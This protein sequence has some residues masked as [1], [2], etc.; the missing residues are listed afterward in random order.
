MSPHRRGGMSPHLPGGTCPGVTLVLSPS[1]GSMEQLGSQLASHLDVRRLRTDIY[2][3]SAEQFNVGATKALL[4]A[5]H[6]AA[7]IRRLRR[8]RGI[9]HFPNHHLARYGMFLHTPYVVTVHDLIR[10]F[11]CGGR[12]PLIHRPTRRDRWTLAVDRAGIRRASAIIAVS[13]RTKDD[14]VHHL[15]LSPGRIT[16]IYPG[17][18]RSRFRPV[19]PARQPYR[20][21]LFV[22]SEHPRKNLS[23]LLGALSLLKRHPDLRGLKLV[24]VGEPGGSEAPFRDCTHRL[25]RAHGLEREVILRGRVSHHELLALYSGAECLV[26][27]SLYEGFGLPPLE[28]MA[29]GCPAIVSDRGAL[30]E[31]AGGGAIVTTP[32]P[33]G[34]ATAVRQVLTDP[35]VRQRLV[36]AGGRHVRKF[37]WS[38]AATQVADVYA[39]AACRGVSPTG[40]FVSDQRE[41][42]ALDPYPNR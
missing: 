22:G 20:Y 19:A 37:S 6:D 21:I 7:F 30:P 11:D 5:L 40:A 15:G 23:A 9:V 18:D 8:L 27:P 16:V 4:S 25:I 12:A 24:K 41:F 14:I 2:E 17:I 32:D 42:P 34:V 26:L 10:H 1:N 39:D 35:A 13:Q 31:T 28:A 29:C 3:R 33:S 36:F 38:H